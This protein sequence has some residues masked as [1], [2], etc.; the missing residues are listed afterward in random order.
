MIDSLGRVG[1]VH[2]PSDVRYTTLGRCAVGEV[3]A[4]GNPNRADFTVLNK[5]AHFAAVAVYNSK[6]IFPVAH[7]SR[8]LFLGYEVLPILT[9]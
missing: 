4:I 6:T 3:V 5:L 7:S 8:L 9:L 2:I 1:V